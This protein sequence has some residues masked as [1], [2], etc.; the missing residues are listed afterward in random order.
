[1]VSVIIPVFNASKFLRCSVESIL[2]HSEVGEILLIEDG[3]T[4]D[5]LQLCTSLKEIDSR[6]KVFTHNENI[7]K[8]AAESRN[9]GI[10]KA[11]FPYISFLDSDDIYYE[12]RFNNAISLLEKNPALSGC[13]GNVLVN[14]VDQNSEKLM[15]VH[16]RISSV[17]LFGY[18]LN[19]GYFHTNS[20]TIRKSIL[21]AIGGFNQFCWPHEDVELWLRLAFY[22]KLESIPSNQPIAEYKIHGNNLSKS[23]SWK[24]RRALWLTVYNLF[25]FKAISWLDRYYILKQLTKTE[26]GRIKKMV[27]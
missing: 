16:Q 6:I 10:R 8:G 14:Y 19:G 2:P 4:D 9:L 11:S 3:S 26:I 7:N 25:F 21:E 23:G 24:S 17:K 22:G 12:N 13:Y 20:I 1:M 18:I 27:S 5:S 15:G